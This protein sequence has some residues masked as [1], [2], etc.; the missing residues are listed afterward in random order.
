[1]AGHTWT[2][3]FPYRRSVGPVIGEFLTG[4]R[5]GRIVGA[6]TATG[7]VLVPA[8]EYDPETSEPIEELV[9]VESSGT[10]TSWVWVSEPK[11]HQPLDRPFAFAHIR[12]GGADTDLF[13]LVDAGSAEAMSDGMSVTARWREEREGKITDIEAFVPVGEASP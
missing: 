8:L 1:L 12:L 2:L 7:R 11:R 3:D 5:D 10:V 6:R 13:H 4:L 9:P